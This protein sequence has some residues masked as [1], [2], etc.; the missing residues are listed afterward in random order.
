MLWIADDSRGDGAEQQWTA[1]DGWKR[2][3]FCLTQRTWNQL[4]TVD[5]SI[6]DLSW[7]WAATNNDHVHLLTLYTT[8][9][10]FTFKLKPHDSY[11]CMSWSKYRSIRHW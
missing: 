1:E 5:A 3:S 10:S 11:G 4:T 9:L 7:I 8:G 2:R 6:S